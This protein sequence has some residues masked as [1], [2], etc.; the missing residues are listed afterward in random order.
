MWTRCC[1]LVVV[2]MILESAGLHPAAFFVETAEHDESHRDVHDADAVGLTGNCHPGLECLFTAVLALH[3]DAWTSATAG[4]A[5]F[6]S[7]TQGRK[8]R[9]LTFWLPPLRHQA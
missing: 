9:T 1:A 4:P 7:T 3:P 6:P 8:G 5:M 2:L